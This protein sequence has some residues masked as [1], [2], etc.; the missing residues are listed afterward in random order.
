MYR[1][2]IIQLKTMLPLI[3]VIIGFA[4]LVVI[5]SQKTADQNRYYWPFEL[6]LIL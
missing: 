2:Y 1:L 3:I 5:V 6:L 4:Y